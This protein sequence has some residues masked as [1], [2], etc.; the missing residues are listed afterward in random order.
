M[1]M[2][3]KDFRDDE[4]FC[5][6]ET[7][8]SLTNRTQS[9]FY[10]IFTGWQSNSDIKLCRHDWLKSFLAVSKQFSSNININT[11]FSQDRIQI[12]LTLA[13]WQ[14]HSYHC[15]VYIYYLFIIERCTEGKLVTHPVGQKSQS[16]SDKNVSPSCNVK[17]CSDRMTHLCKC[18]GVWPKT[19][20][21]PY[22]LPCQIWLFYVKVCRHKYRQTPKIVEPMLS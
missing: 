15:L 9:I 21:S 17:R 20:P 16:L 19:R 11:S 10:E 13:L 12:R 3:L 2:M 22:V 1:M 8:L 14:W 7:Q 5:L 18:N 6:Q 4:L